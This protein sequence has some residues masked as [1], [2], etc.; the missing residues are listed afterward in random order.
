[1]DSVVTPSGF[2]AGFATDS[3]EDGPNW[4]AF[5]ASEVGLGLHNSIQSSQGFANLNTHF[6]RDAIER[7]S[8]RGTTRAEIR[9]LRNH[10]ENMYK[11]YNGYGPYQFQNPCQYAQAQTGVDSA[12]A[13]ELAILRS[14]VAR[15]RDDKQDASN[16][17]ILEALAALKPKV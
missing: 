12:T 3:R 11:G 15:L 14:E 8:E 9:D 6:V 2:G 16:K 13:T 10:Y 17:A 1:M 5:G 7:A 4:S